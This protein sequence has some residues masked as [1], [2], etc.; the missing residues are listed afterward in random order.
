[1]EHAVK[2]KHALIKV[3]KMVRTGNTVL[4]YIAI[5]SFSISDDETKR[6]RDVATSARIIAH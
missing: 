2:V 3:E 4:I 1:M 6:F 5:F